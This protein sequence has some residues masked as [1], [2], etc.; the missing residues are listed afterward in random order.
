MVYVYYTKCSA[1]L[2][3]NRLAHYLQLV[4]PDVKA[5]AQRFR[6]WQ[7]V[8]SCLFG[9]LLL[10][11]ALRE[12]GGAPYRLEDVKTDAHQRPYLDDAVDF[13]ITHSEELTVCALSA[14]TRLG[15]D[16]EKIRPINLA[17]LQEQCSPDEWQQ[18]AESGQRL[19]RFYELWTQK[20]AAVKADGRGVTL[21]LKHVNVGPANQV[22]VDRRTFYLHALRLD[23]MYAACLA[24]DTPRYDLKV[25]EVTFA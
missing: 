12:W 20:E 7:D 21:P 6:N 11:R 24:T 22:T 3:A 4:P 5:K 25:C 14:V 18:L 17:P 19:T 13:N 9:R 15:V 10:L 16:V 8:H 23:D 2:P 1:P